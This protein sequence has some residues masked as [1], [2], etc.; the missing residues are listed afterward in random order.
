MAG[1]DIPSQEERS[2]L[3]QNEKLLSAF[4]ERYRYSTLGS[5][6]KG[7][8]HNLN[9]SLQILS[10]H[11]EL[12]Q[13]MLGKRGDQWESQVQH[14]MGQC[15][16][17]LDKFRMIVETLAEK[18]RHDEQDSPQSFNLNDLIEEELAL[19]HHNLFFKHQVSVKRELA[20]HLPLLTGYY[21]E[22]S[23]GLQNVLRN[24]IEAM[25]ETERKELT[26]RTEFLGEFLEV[27]IGDTGCGV[28]EKVRPHL[29]QPFFT[30]KGG[31]H[32]GLGLYL[33]K[34]LLAPYG[35]SFDV[36]SH[37]GETLF[38]IRFPVPG[39]IRKP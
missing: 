24:A 4:T 30:T 13:M 21:I 6:V 39:G 9:G 2:L 17:Q 27:G 33:S 29:F 16:D 31:R 28:S 3:V 32:N 18:A 26:L 15:L 22:F 20:T 1:Q 34:E 11:M 5:L 23:E 12:L 19:L 25:E 36:S 8:I 7:I 37:E 35:A 10:M 38:T 14:R